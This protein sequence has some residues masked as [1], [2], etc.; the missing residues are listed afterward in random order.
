MKQEDFEKQLD[1]L[2]LGQR[3]KAEGL[4]S[5]M[6]DIDA[7]KFSSNVKNISQIP[8]EN[9]LIIL[10]DFFDYCKYNTLR[11]ND[12]EKSCTNLMDTIS[13][14]LRQKHKF[15]FVLDKQIPL[16]F[17]TIELEPII[18]RLSKY[19]VLFAYDAFGNSVVNTIKTIADEYAL[20]KKRS[21]IVTQNKTLGIL[22]DN[23][24][25]VVDY[26]LQ[27][28]PYSREGIKHYNESTVIWSNT[29]SGVCDYLNVLKDNNCWDTI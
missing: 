9:N 27:T 23:Y 10:I 3:I 20:I 12:L 21:L 26:K 16:L 11:N 2:S 25:A 29:Y 28:I 5:T 14:G 1:S 17:K 18:K 13:K 22:S 15:V 8:Y 4:I 6:L 19:K 24:T 7:N